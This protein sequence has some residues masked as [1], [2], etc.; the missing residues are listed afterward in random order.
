[1]PMTP[2][3]RL[4][5]QGQLTLNASS[6]AALVEA[7]LDISE[8]LRGDG[9]VP[10]EVH[11][12][13]D[14]QGRSLW[15][16][17]LPELGDS[18]S[19]TTPPVAVWQKLSWEWLANRFGLSP[20]QSL[21]NSSFIESDVLPWL[22]TADNS[23]ERQQMQEALERDH[24]TES[25][26]LAAERI[27]LQ[28]ENERLRAQNVALQQVDAERLVSF[29]PALFPRAFTVLGATDL[30]LLC[31][32]VEPLPIP[33]PYPEPSEETLR[34]L[35]KQ[36]RTLPLPFQKQIVSFVATLPQR[37]KLQPRPE[38]REL[39]HELEGN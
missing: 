18:H 16:E 21:E 26:K 4:K 8:R 12:V 29:L 15:K 10:S 5:I 22:V 3:H 35:Q 25:Q 11:W 39:I 24:Q 32:R 23:V 33:N 31:K 36:F 28:Q 7:F 37:Q 9:F 27:R 17:S 2:P 38:M 30:A 34:T 13:I 20:Q 14:K 1:M 6:K 19:P